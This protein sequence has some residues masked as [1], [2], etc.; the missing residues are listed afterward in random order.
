MQS[1]IASILAPHLTP[2]GLVVKCLEFASAHLEHIMDFT[3]MRALSS[4]FALF[5]QVVRNVLHYNNAHSD[6]PMQSDQLDRCVSCAQRL[7]KT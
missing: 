3:R 4:L 2:D 5:N 1:N 7:R 6:F